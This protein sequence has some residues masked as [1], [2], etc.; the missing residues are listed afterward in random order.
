MSEP[1]AFISAEVYEYQAYLSTGVGKTWRVRFA[2]DG[3]PVMELLTP[4]QEQ[5]LFALRRRYPYP[6]REIWQSAAAR[7]DDYNRR[8]AAG[9]DVSNEVRPRLP[10]GSDW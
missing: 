8:E 6:E 5:E 2:A 7:V 1:D 4:T 9:E 10:G 3:L